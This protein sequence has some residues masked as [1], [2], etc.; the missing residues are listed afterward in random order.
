MRFLFIILYVSII[1]VGC[2]NTQISKEESSVPLNE[3]QT[4]NSEMEKSY[5]QMI[6]LIQHE[7]YEDVI[8]LFEELYKREDYSDYPKKREVGILYLFANAMLDKA[9]GDMEG[10]RL[11][12]DLIDNN[13]PSEISNIVNKEVNSVKQTNNISL[14][15]EIPTLI[16]NEKYS[17]A[18]ELLYSIPENN[19]V[20]TLEKYVSALESE[21]SGDFGQTVAFLSDIPKDYNGLLSKE[22][23]E[24]LTK[25]ESDIKEHQI[26]LAEINKDQQRPNPQIG[27]MQDE[28]I[29]ST[30][31]KPEDINRTITEY[32][33]SEQWV[34]SIDRYIYFDDGVVTAIQD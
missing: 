10:Y 14:Y 11:N 4:I 1:L 16:K 9:K 24:K 15:E 2:S 8:T 7:N 3:K 31:G 6:E 34:Y 32:G 13:I 25:Y 22:I 19:E 23:S 5:K 20:I 27:M 33:T 26:I 17:K 29:N 28:V 12:L 30:W 21:K 18:L